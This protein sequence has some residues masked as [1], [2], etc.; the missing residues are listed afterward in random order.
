MGDGL[1]SLRDTSFNKD[2]SMSLLS[3]GSISLY[4]TFKDFWDDFVLSNQ[5]HFPWFFSYLE[6]HLLR[7]CK[8][9]LAIEKKMTAIFFTEGVRHKV[10][11]YKE[12]HSVCIPTP[13]E[14]A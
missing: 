6:S 3:A 12:Y 1:K 14:K 10:H 9:A 7:F 2:L 8:M 11:T 4:N 5:S 13:G